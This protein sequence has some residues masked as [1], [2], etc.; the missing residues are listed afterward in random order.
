MELYSKSW[1]T[2]L[3][4]NEYNF[5]KNT[6]QEIYDKVK[7][8]DFKKLKNKKAQNLEICKEDYEKHS[9]FIKYSSFETGVS[10]FL[11]KK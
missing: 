7:D 11:I 8:I 3:N 9:K 5:L 1:R 10:A 6:T 2:V 4:R